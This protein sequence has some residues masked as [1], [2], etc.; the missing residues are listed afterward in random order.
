MK[1]KIASITFILIHFVLYAQHDTVVS[2]RGYKI[3]PN[4]FTSLSN[5]RLSDTRVAYKS[6]NHEYFVL[7]SFMEKSKSYHME[8]FD[9][10]GKI[11]DAFEINDIKD[12]AMQNC[13]ISPLGNLIHFES[14]IPFEEQLGYF[15]QSYLKG[16]LIFEEDSVSTYCFSKNNNVITYFKVNGNGLLF[17]KN[18]DTNETWSK[19]INDTITYTAW[20]SDN[21]ESIMAHSIDKFFALD[22]NGNIRW[23]REKSFF[24]GNLVMS[25]LGKHIIVLGLQE[26]KVYTFDDLKLMW[27]KRNAEITGSNLY[28]S[29][30]NWLDDKNL[31]Y[32]SGKN[33]IN[34]YNE[35]GKMVKELPI[36]AQSYFHVTD[37]RGSLDIVTD[38]KLHHHVN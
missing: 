4:T 24:D 35:E 17:Y 20:V 26:V 36:K 30:A 2:F 13:Y 6:R 7:S 5:E 10:K 14:I 12:Y 11:S 28:P 33:T 25:D 23:S 1:K 18:L 32:I 9:R 27:S 22:K 34:V 38:D 19:H 3:H 31:I 16:K 8:V 29:Y 15:I 21:G 37:N